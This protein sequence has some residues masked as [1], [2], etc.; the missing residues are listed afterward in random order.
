MTRRIIGSVGMATMPIF[1]RRRPKGGFLT[2]L[3]IVG[4][5]KAICGYE[6][7]SPRTWRMIDRHGWTRQ[8]GIRPCQRCLDAEEFLKRATKGKD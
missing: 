4:N 6:P 3:I 2:H 5:Y 1:H 8:E 7:S